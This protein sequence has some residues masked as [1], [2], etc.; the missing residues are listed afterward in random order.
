M[1]KILDLTR[2][3]L[4]AFKVT[5]K[6]KKADYDVLNTMLKNAEQ[7]YDTIKLYIELES[8]EGIEPEAVWEDI[9]SYFKHFK[10]LSKIAIVSTDDRIKT[11]T[12]ISKP[13]IEG[14]ARYFHENELITARAWVSE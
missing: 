2:D 8:I 10:D 12:K 5:G 3:N 13:F 1:F 14:Q 11:L 9:K 6:V 4:I 7:N